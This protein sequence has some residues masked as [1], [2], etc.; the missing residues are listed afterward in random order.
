M[1]KR[2]K[3]ALI[4]KDLTLYDLAARIG[5]SRVLVSLILSGK[6][7]GYAHRRTIA[8]ALGVSVKDL[9][10]KKEAA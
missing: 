9:V 7:K 6:H 3:I 10:E 2:V 1:T 5:R 8:R 4:E